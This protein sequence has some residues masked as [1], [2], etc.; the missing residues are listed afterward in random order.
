MDNGY[1]ACVYSRVKNSVYR[2]AVVYIAY[3][4]LYTTAWYCGIRTGYWLPGYWL[5]VTG[6][7]LLVTG[8]WL[9]VTGYW[10][11]VTGYWLLV[12]NW[13]IMIS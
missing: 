13:C 4:A 11:L 7:W 1:T 3:R 9:L 6:Y 12:T 10:L 2:V 8:Y 5:L